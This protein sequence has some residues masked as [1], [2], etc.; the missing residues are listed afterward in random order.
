[1]L[2]LALLRKHCNIDFDDD[3]DLLLSYAESA[4]SL[5]V[6]ELRN[7]NAAE[8]DI[9]DEKGELRPMVRAEVLSQVAYFYA[10]REAVA[11]GSAKLSPFGIER[12]RTLLWRAKV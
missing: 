12:L 4:E 6:R 8:E 9:Y 2:E 10:N 1:M 7:A 3:D 5:V 11:A